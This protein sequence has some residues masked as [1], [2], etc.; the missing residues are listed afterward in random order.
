MLLPVGTDAPIYHRPLATC[1]LIVANIA[2]FWQTS[3]GTSDDG[4]ILRYGQLNPPE[5]WTSAFLHFDIVHLVGNMVFLWV[6]GLITEGKLGWW[7]FLLLYLGLCGATGFVIQSVTLAY[8]GCSIGA[9]GASGVIYGL[10]AICLVWAPK[11]CIDVVMAWGIGM[12]FRIYQFELT[13][14][15]FALYYIGKDFLIG[16][17]LLD[18]AISTPVLHMLGAIVGFPVGVL[19]LRLGWVECE[20]WDLFSLLRRRIPGAENAGWLA[21]AAPGGRSPESADRH[22]AARSPQRQVARISQ[23]IDNDQAEMAFY[24]YRQLQATPAGARLDEPELR[25]L[26]E[27]LQVCGK[28]SAVVE[29]LDEYL[30]EHGGSCPRRAIRARLLQAG[31]LVKELH[32]PRAALRT[33]KPLDAEQLSSSQRQFLQSVRREAT[34]QIEDGVMELRAEPVLAAVP[35][36]RPPAS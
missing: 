23:L 28:W 2:A 6:F 31:I 12:W 33:I 7:R 21:T 25:R 11:N 16:W 15:T 29:L 19:L 9:G 32:R 27:S 1:G 22:P 30:A 20:G 10:M 36:S 3:G 26:I 35:T 8:D 17:L 5:W 18:F 24:R 4:W 14:F 13:I 34:R